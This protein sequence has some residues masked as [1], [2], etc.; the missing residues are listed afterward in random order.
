MMPGESTR[1]GK[2]ITAC[3]EMIMR[4]WCRVTT[5]GTEYTR[6]GKVRTPKILLA[7][8]ENF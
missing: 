1:I 5:P 2:V 4:A 7:H 3:N 6:H 8:H